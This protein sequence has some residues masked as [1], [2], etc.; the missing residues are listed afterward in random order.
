MNADQDDSKP[1]P[2]DKAEPERGLRAGQFTLGFLFALT[3]LV[4]VVCG[5][6]EWHGSGVL[7]VILWN[8]IAALIALAV[9]RKKR[10]AAAASLFSV[11][12][13]W[14]VAFLLTVV[15]NVHAYGVAHVTDFNFSLLGPAILAF[16]GWV[17]FAVPVINF[18]PAN[19]F[20]YRPWFAPIAA[21][22]LALVANGVLV[23][24]GVPRL[25]ESACF[26]A[27]IGVVAGILFP[28]LSRSR[29]PSFVLFCGPSI[30]FLSFWCL[31]W[32][33]LENLTPGFTYTYGS[34]DVQARSVHRVFQSIRVGDSIKDLHCRYPA[35]FRSPFEGTW[36]VD[37]IGRYEYVSYIEIDQATGSVNRVGSELREC[38]H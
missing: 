30:L 32:P 34:P 33:L 20:L 24:T 35:L 25:W 21:P 36:R 10:K 8:T 2:D 31:L 6:T 22:C 29:C 9:G 11:F 28:L 19:G 7:V 13:G 14:C 1:T 12:A 27:I 15:W 3:T 26:P 17:V 38:R 5:L 37:E 4:A 18:A 16:L 23:G